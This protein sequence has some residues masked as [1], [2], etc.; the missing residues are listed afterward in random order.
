MSAIQTLILTPLTYVGGMFNSLSMLPTW[1]RRLSLYDPMFY[2]MNVFRY[3]FLGISDVSFRMAISIISGCALILFF[4]AVKF[5]ARG[6][7]VRN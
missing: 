6:S 5:M 4:A 3:G 1:A 7:G 2:M